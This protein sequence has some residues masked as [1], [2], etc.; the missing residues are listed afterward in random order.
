MV[1]IKCIADGDPAPNVTLSFKEKDLQGNL[2]EK[3]T[4]TTLSVHVNITKA[5]HYG[6]YTC[7]ASNKLKKGVKHEV[8]VISMYEDPIYCTRF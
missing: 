6:V 2:V 5:D 3:P 7:T 1:E 8:N 4:Q